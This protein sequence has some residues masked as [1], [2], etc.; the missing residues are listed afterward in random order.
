MLKPLS[1]LSKKFKP[2]NYS[3]IKIVCWVASQSTGI[4]GFWPQPITFLF[5]EK[6]KFK[7]IFELN[8]EN[9]FEAQN[10]ILSQK[11]EHGTFS[12]SFSNFV[13]SNFFI[14][15]SWRNSQNWSRLWLEIPR[16][17]FFLSLV[18]LI[19]LINLSILDHFYFIVS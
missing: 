7:I 5:F 3:K 6:T 16:T 1:S 18:T 14:F 9:I 8:K 13:K 15:P 10:Y 4:V 17:Y 2:Q 11:F 12:P 19:G